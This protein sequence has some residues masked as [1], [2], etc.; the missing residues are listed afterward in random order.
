MA[1]PV[2]STFFVPPLTRL[3]KV[4][5]LAVGFTLLLQPNP[6]FRADL[7][8][9]GSALLPAQQFARLLV[10]HSS[11]GEDGIDQTPRSTSDPQAV[12]PKLD[13][14]LPLLPLR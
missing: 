8:Q 6:D 1:P 9:V 2:Q 7:Q 3:T 4:A 11:A 13:V 5:H 10:C 12:G 14:G